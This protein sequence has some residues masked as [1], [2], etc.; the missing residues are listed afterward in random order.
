[1]DLLRAVVNFV[2]DGLGPQ[3]PADHDAHDQRAGGHGQTLGQGVHEVQPAVVPGAD[4]DHLLE[5]YPHA[6][7]AQ[8]VH[9]HQ[10]GLNHDGH[11][12]PEHGL[13]AVALL[14]LALR[15][16]QQE[17]DDH[18][19]Q[20]DGGGNGRHQHEQVE[21]HAEQGADGAHGLEH[22]LKGDEQQLGTAEGGAG[23]VGRHGGG[24]DG[25]ARHDGHQGVRKN[26]HH[27]VL[28]DVLGFLHIG[29]VGDGDA[30]GQ[31][32]GEEHLP[33]CGSQDGDE[34]G[35]LGNEARL[36]RVAGK[37][38]EFQAL[39]RAGQG[40][41]AD[42]DDHQHHKEGGHA[43]VVEL[44]N[45][46]GDAAPV[47]E[48]ADNHE[49]KGEHDAAKGVGQHGAEQVRP[50][51][52]LRPGEGQVAQVQGHVLDAVAAQ[53]RVEAQN[54]EGGE[55]RQPAHPLEA[56]G[57]CVVSADGAL[58]GFPAHGQ[59]GHHDAEAHEDGQQHIDDQECEAAGLSHFVGEAP[60]VAQAHGRTDG[61]HQEA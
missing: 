23:A 28:H 58:A 6:V 39:R 38:H 37:E 34:A 54:D 11:A 53:N 3:L 1:M 13:G 36:H 29:A 35:S 59:L 61:G 41:G 48:V 9:G 17:G 56:R 12:D 4:A 20:G 26:H 42:D 52:D 22:V 5:R 15:M 44:L 19:D 2:G 24:D 33:A 27:R 7:A 57:Q 30:H 10:S 51:L 21:N 14:A 25:D 47:D 16:V 45:A 43:H 32:Q 40:D 31:G 55:H 18:L 8:A 46:P 60:D 49:Q 50:G